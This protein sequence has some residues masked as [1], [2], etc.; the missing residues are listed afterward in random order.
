MRAATATT[1]AGATGMGDGRSAPP[2]DSRSPFARPP[3]LRLPVPPPVET[4]ADRP[5]I[6]PRGLIARAR[7]LGLAVGAAATVSGLALGW[8]HV[9]RRLPVLRRVDVPVARRPELR[10]LTILHLSD[11]H[12][13]Q[14]QRFIVDFLRDVAARERFDF[15]VSTGDNLGDADG[16]QLVGEAYEPLL[17]HPGAFVLGSNDYY[18]PRRRGWATYMLGDPEPRDARF[19]AAGDL[20]TPDL[21]WLDLVRRLRGAGWTDLTNQAATV[22]VPVGAGAT[23]THEDARG[24][25]AGA[26]PNAG[27]D[28]DQRVSLIGVDDPHIE[29]DRVPELPEGW[30]DAGSLRLAVTHSPYRRVLDRFAI[31]GADL[32]LAGHTHGGQVRLPG[33]GALVTNCDLPR[34]YARGLHTWST[35]EHRAWLHV[36]AGLG[37]SPFAP[38]R[39]DCRPEATLLRI[40][41]ADR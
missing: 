38:I 20:R 22:D 27:P 3:Q 28:A 4:L 6:A 9:E 13:Y 25:A 14:G 39:F 1:A 8:A 18:S 7:A 36:S 15:V 35:G 10:P 26:S 17:G 40:V 31:D 33:I 11:L 34:E 16:V 5:S 41:P 24:V 19:T 21:P 37:T 30:G 32:I 23:S 12:L 29:R 2:A